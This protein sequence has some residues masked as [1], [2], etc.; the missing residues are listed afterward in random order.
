LPKLLDFGIAKLL[1]ADTAEAPTQTVMRLFTPCYAA[2]EQISG[3]VITTATDV[4]ALGVVLYEL[5]TGVRPDTIETAPRDPAPAL[6]RLAPSAALGRNAA[7]LPARRALRGDVDRIVLKAM[8]RAPDRRY[9]SAQA[10]A[11]DLR[12]HLAGRP[13]TAVGDRWR[14]R[15]HKFVRRHRV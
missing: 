2:P 12:N 7:D 3:G 6:A 13:V 10:L 8:A 1:A 4:Y 15:L 11:D 5:L 9:S 14:Y